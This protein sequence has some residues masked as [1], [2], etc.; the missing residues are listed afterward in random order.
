VKFDDKP[1]THRTAQPESK[2]RFRGHE[3]PSLVF[4]TSVCDGKQLS[5][6]FFALSVESGDKIL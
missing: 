5:K 6:A 4:P 1:S 2:R 3:L